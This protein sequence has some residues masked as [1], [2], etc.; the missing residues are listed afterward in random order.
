MNACWRGCEPRHLCFILH[1]QSQT[2]CLQPSEMRTRGTLHIILNSGDE[3]AFR[4]SPQAMDFRTAAGR[5][6][7]LLTSSAAWPTDTEV[8]FVDSRVAA[9]AVT[10]QIMSL[11][12]DLIEAGRLFS[13]GSSSNDT[14]SD[15]QARGSS[16]SSLLLCSLCICTKSDAP[17]DS[18]IYILS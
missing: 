2:G 13:R 11:T 7:A 6:A 16:V 4:V 12:H 8:G 1:Q 9:T 18:E 14:S 10:A 15:L 5:E 3:S 17:E